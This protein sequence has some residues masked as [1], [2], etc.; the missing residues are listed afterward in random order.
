MYH[1]L[2]VVICWV[3][4]LGAGNTCA[5]YQIMNNRKVWT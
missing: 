4:V 3:Y 1:V 5:V 2:V